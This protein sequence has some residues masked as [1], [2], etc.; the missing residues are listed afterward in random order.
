MKA[1]NKFIQLL[2][3]HGW[4][5]KPMPEGVGYRYKTT[6]RNKELA[7][8]DAYECLG[9]TDACEINFAKIYVQ[10]ENEVY[11]TYVEF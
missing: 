4:E 11:V 10:K 5:R 2:K 8:Y 1:Q 6:N 7:Y 9:W 3:R